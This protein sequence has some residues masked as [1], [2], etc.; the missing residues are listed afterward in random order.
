MRIWPFR[1]SGIG[2]KSNKQWW[3]SLY[4]LFTF[5][6]Y[7][8][9]LPAA[10]VVTKTMNLRYQ[11]FSQYILTGVVDLI[12]YFYLFI[13]LFCVLF[14]WLVNWNCS[15]AESPVIHDVLVPAPATRSHP[16]SEPKLILCTTGWHGAQY[17]PRLTILGQRA[18]KASLYNVNGL[19]VF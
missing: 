1:I 19:F 4:F 2:H 3:L 13:C 5:F 12:W 8:Y 10:T 18:G 11:L 17:N 7:K 14:V 15:T 6:L 9:V 16:R